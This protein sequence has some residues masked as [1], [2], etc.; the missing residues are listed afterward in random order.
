VTRLLERTHELAEL[1]AAVA[2]AATGAGSVV[3]VCGEA[4]IGKSSLVGAVPGLLPPG[5]RLLMGSCDDLATPRTLGPFRD[6][7]DVAGPPLAAALRDAGDRDRVFD[8]LHQELSGPGQPTVLAVEDVHWADDATLDGLAYLV[9]RVVA[10]PAVLLLTYR[11]GEIAAADPLHRVLG[12][13]ARTGRVRRLTPGRLSVAAVRQLAAAGRLDPHDVHAVTGGNPFFIGEVLAAGDTSGVPPTIVD[14]VLPRVRGLPVS[15][16]DA[17]AQLAVVPS[18]VDRWL[19][20]ALLPDGL[21]AVAPAEQRGLLDVTPGRVAFHHELIRRAI[22]DALPVA[23]QV[24]LNGRVLAALVDREGSDLSRI[25]HHAALAGNV[26]AIVRYAP[27]AARDAASAGSHRAAAAHLGLVLQHRHRFPPSERADLLRDYATECNRIGE[28]PAAVGAQQE[29][30][31]LRRTAGDPRA[32]GADL[33]ALSVLCWVAGDPDRME[34]S[35]AE[36]VAVL[37]PAGDDRLLAL[38]LANM[39]RLHMLAERN[40]DSVRVGERAIAMARATGDRAV[41]SQALN[42]VGVAH[43]QSGHPAEGIPTIEESLR[44]ALADGAVEEACRAYANLTYNLCLY[45]RFDE[46]GSHLVDAIDF[47]ERN[48]YFAYQYHLYGH[49]SMLHL[50][51]GD[52]DRAVADAELVMNA[53][54]PGRPQT[55]NTALNV[56]GRIQ[57]RRGQSTGDAVLAE[58]WEFAERSRELQHRAP[59][60]AARAEAAWLRGDRAAVAPLVEPVHADACRQGAVTIR[61]ELDYWLMRAGR[62]VAPVAPDHPYMLHASGRWREAAVAWQESGCP[63]EY[64]VAL[65][66]SSDPDD[67]LASLDELDRLRAEPLARQVRRR[68][69]EFG[70]SRIPR[71]PL[72]ATRENPGGLTDRQLEVAKL[73]A[74]G[75]T[76]PEIAARLVLS[77]RTIENHVA[78]ILGKLGARSR[79]DLATRTAA[80]G[81]SLDDA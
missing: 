54:P 13:A 32:L 81:L 78:A 45:R 15:T 49:R 73:L 40:R 61:V 21:A 79:R 58:A 64:A 37:E 43:C 14:A 23:R 70:I 50:S 53:L 27:E 80:L 63:Y 51:T 71:G 2:E 7:V 60:A 62:P 17:L 68:L 24:T 39:S 3:L 56:L 66:D 10:V 75:L 47:A 26:D 5:G 16:Q 25:V 30:I 33:R 8:A 20:D 59:I 46:L 19:L 22:V 48:E 77:V 9:R 42:T 44:I 69:R 38:A 11:D 65:A 55:R 34:S 36:A 57:V 31:E 1:A 52:W 28:I 76:N 18:T 6:L 74:A 35:A 72:L 12:Q 41:L 29:A 4:G 67:L